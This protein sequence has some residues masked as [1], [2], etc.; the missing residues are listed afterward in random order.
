[1]AEVNAL[2]PKRIVIIANGDLENPKFYRELLC[3]DDYIICADGGSRHARTLGLTPDLIIG[4]LDSVDPLALPK[5]ADL[6]PEVISYPA[7]KDYSDLELAVGHAVKLKPQEILIIGALGGSRVDHSLFNLML[8][9]LPLEAGIPARIIDHR[10]ELVLI[11]DDI[12]VECLPGSYVSL[13]P[14][15]AE[16][17]GVTTEGLRYPL[18]KELLQHGSSR[19]LSNELI[20]DRGR[21]SISRGILLVIVTSKT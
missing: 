14:I 12:T 16:V 9:I 4:D 21:V 17:D 8:L 19:G 2:Q 13:F 11:E 3:E 6:K 18:Q 10:Q 20:G 1:M 5:A 7:E 15:T